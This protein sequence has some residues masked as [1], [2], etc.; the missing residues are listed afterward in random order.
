MGARLQYYYSENRVYYYTTSATPSQGMLSANP[1][2][3]RFQ[4]DLYPPKYGAFSLDPNND[5]SESNSGYGLVRIECQFGIKFYSAVVDLSRHGVNA[6][7]GIQIGESIKSGVRYEESET[8]TW[9]GLTTAYDGVVRRYDWT[10]PGSQSQAH[11]LGEFE[12][13]IHYQ[14]L[15]GTQPRSEAYGGGTVSVKY[16][17]NMDGNPIKFTGNSEELNYYTSGS[18]YLY[19]KGDLIPIE[20]GDEKRAFL[21]IYE[22][23]SGNIIDIFNF[24]DDDPGSHLGANANFYFYKTGQNPCPPGTTYDPICKDCICD[25][26]VNGTLANIINSIVL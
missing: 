25:V 12:E 23:V 8:T 6:S 21:R 14:V 10:T 7:I 15:T 5:W 1:V 17:A 18:F 20:T 24:D 13:G 3:T 2:E 9:G 19:K 16:L 22:N 4:G 11:E 26:I